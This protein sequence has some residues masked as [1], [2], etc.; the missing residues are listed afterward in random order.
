MRESIIFS[1]LPFE[2]AQFS[3]MQNALFAVLLLAPLFALP[4]CLVVNNRMAFFSDAIGHAALTGVAI[5]ALAGIAAPLPSMLIFACCL[6]FVISY[7]RRVSAVPADTVISLVMAGSMALGIVIL[8]RKGGFG[9]YSRYLIGDLLSLSTT[10]LYII[11]V[12]LLFVIAAWLFM[13]NRFFLVSFN[14]TIARSRNVNVFG[15]DLFFSVM[16]AFIVTL[17]VQWIGILVINS[18]LVLPAAAARNISASLRAYILTALFISLIS[19]VTGLVLSF[20]L[21]TAAG[22]TIVLAA[23]GFYILS[24]IGRFLVSYKL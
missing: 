2:W 6:A 7:M 19:S 13:F 5:G 3:F 22:A 18:L 9:R 4:G 17:A 15:Y 16:T 11:A 1:L 21:S 24:L 8:S 10:D 20:Y 12:T 14:E 23:L